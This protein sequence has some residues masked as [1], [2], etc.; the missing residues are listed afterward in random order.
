[1]QCQW[2]SYLKLL[3]PWLK[4]PVNRLGSDTLTELRLRLGAAPEL[5]LLTH[6]AW[7]DRVVTKDDINY[8]INAA[9][10]YSPWTAST[11]AA[12]FITAPGGHRLGLSG[13]SSSPEGR[14]KGFYSVTSICVR[15]ARDVSGIA[16]KLSRSHNSILLI[17]APGCGKTTL[18]R[19]LI[20]QHSEKS[21]GSIVVIDERGELFPIEHDQFCFPPGR[22]TDVLTGCSKTDAIVMMIRCMRPSVIAVDEITTEADCVALLKA[23]WC[24]VRIF[25]TAHAGSKEELF[26]RVVYKPL[27]DANIFDT[28]VVL[29][30]DKSWR[31]EKMYQ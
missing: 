9:T 6:S 28:L 5:V 1:M 12:G 11:A 17:G 8:C 10:Q 30:P 14:H 23:A 18:L 31:L 2:Q 19:D 24:G 22:R 21:D 15:V 20:R 13:I 16:A 29:R 26:N 7:L 4:D 25:A 27:L 3:P